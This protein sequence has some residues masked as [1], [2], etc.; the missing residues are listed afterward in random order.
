MATV[1]TYVKRLLYRALLLGVLLGA[2]ATLVF[3]SKLFDASVSLP[4]FACGL[5]AMFLLWNMAKALKGLEKVLTD[6]AHE[7]RGNITI[8]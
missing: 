5:G 8:E 6:H 1:I 4:I 2:M 3:S 7:I